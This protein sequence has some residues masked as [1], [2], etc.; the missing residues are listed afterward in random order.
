LW[1][2][3][4]KRPLFVEKKLFYVDNSLEKYAFLVEKM[5]EF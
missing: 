1:I 3:W 4:E 2:T 5:E